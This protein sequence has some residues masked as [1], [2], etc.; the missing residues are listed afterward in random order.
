[1]GFIV[2]RIKSYAL[3]RLKEASTWKALAGFV[4]TMI[5]YKLTDGQIEAAGA[6][7]TAVYALLSALMPDKLGGAPVPTAPV[8]VPVKGMLPEEEENKYRIPGQFP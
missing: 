7:G 6:A 8:N 3:N 1:M 5:G 4:A 2:N